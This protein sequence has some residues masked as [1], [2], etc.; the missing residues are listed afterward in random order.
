MLIILG[1]SKLICCLFYCFIGSVHYLRPETNNSKHTIYWY[2]NFYSGPT[3]NAT[4]SLVYKLH[5]CI[6]VVLFSNNG[7]QF[8]IEISS[9]NLKNLYEIN[10]PT[11][12]LKIERTIQCIRIID[13]NWRIEFLLWDHRTMSIH[14]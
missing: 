8:L 1:I 11:A 12:Y 14:Y 13:R 3:L 5:Q 6:H 10:S 9:G 4:F 2:R 7:L